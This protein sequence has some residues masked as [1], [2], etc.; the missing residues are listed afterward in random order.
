MVVC[1]R[2]RFV[3]LLDIFSPGNELLGAFES[4]QERAGILRTTEDRYVALNDDIQTIAIGMQYGIGFGKQFRI[5]HK[6]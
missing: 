1:R 2:H 6:V 3:A 5:K 4:I